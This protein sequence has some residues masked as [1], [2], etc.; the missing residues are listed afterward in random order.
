[1]ENPN[2]KIDEIF[3]QRLHDAEVPPPPFVWP[4][5]EHALQKRR[6]RWILWLFTF[7]TVAASVWL[8]QARVMPEGSL[9][10]YPAPDQNN[11]TMV[12][13]SGLSTAT[14][15]TERAALATDEN[16]TTA[17]IAETHTTSSYTP[18]SN[19][20]AS[21][22]RQQQSGDQKVSIKTASKIDN[23]NSST[24]G[25]SGEAELSKQVGGISNPPAPILHDFVPLDNDVALFTTQN[26]PIVPSPQVSSALPSKEAAAPK[27][28][29]PVSKRKKAQPKLC[30]DFA[31][32][33]SAWL[34][35]IYAGPSLAQRTLTSRLDDRPYLNQRL[36]TEHRSVAMNAGIR[37]SLMFNRNFLVRTGLHYDQITEVFEYI[38]PT[39]VTY[40]LKF[41]A[42][43]P[44][45][46]TLGVQYGEN[47]LKTY[48]RYAMLDIPL[49]IGMEMR[50]GRSGFSINAG[51]SANVLFQKR[52]VI[53]DP[54]T[55][56]PARF[57]PVPD[58][59][60]NIGPNASLSQEV[61]RA[62]VGLS[63][64]ASIQWYWHLTPKFRVFVEPSFRQVLRPVSLA[65]H[66]VEHRYGILGL[67]LGATKIF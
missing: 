13:E 36:A 19:K 29:K 22:K 38:D 40:I 4:A 9:G 58:K 45:P 18:E 6:R 67:R 5:V 61:F 11:T 27:T 17:S 62:N 21:Q 46:D 24:K 12:Q 31:R 49:L 41:N 52:G 51:V 54:L 63:A 7:G 59:P 37:A 35:D 15:I 28:L 39:S 55:H 60:K 25:I 44:I 26:L 66:P 1:M 57:G 65:S 20:Q 33:P 34:L 30:Y 32:H 56:E 50:Q 8:W 42:G 64:T 10:S 14:V 43:D 48:N 23:A 2:H 47:Y 16:A 3:R 53:I